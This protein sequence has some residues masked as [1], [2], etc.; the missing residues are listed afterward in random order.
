M[1]KEAVYQT[2]KKAILKLSSG[3]NIHKS[4]NVLGTLAVTLDLDDKKMFAEAS[5]R[6]IKYG[7]RLAKQRGLVKGKVIYR[8]IGGKVVPIRL[9]R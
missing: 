8:R 2:L 4:N 5:R 6:A 3:A 1:S 7:A 9:K